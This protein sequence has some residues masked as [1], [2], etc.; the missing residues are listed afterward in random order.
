MFVCW[1]FKIKIQFY[2]TDKLLTIL[3]RIVEEEGVEASYYFLL[4]YILFPTGVIEKPYISIS[5]FLA[6]EYNL[7][8]IKPED[9]DSD[10]ENEFEE[11]EEQLSPEEF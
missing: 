6:E 4:D 8:N 7:H 2:L 5:E 1:L 11:T 9:L 3:A 10:N